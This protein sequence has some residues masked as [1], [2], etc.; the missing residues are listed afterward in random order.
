MVELSSRCLAFAE[1]VVTIICPMLLTLS[2]KKDQ[3]P[4]LPVHILA[5][6]GATV[7]TGICPLL[8][9]CISKTERCRTVGARWPSVTRGF[10]ATISSTCLLVLACWIALRLVSKNFVMFAG[11]VSG[12]GLLL[13][14]FSYWTCSTATEQALLPEMNGDARVAKEKEAKELRSM[15]DKSHELLSGVTGILFLGLGGLALEGLLSTR[16][17]AGDALKVHMTIGHLIC[18]FGVTLMFFPMIPPRA[19]AMKICMVYVSDVTVAVGTAAQLGTIM[20]KLMGRKGFGFLAF[21][22]IILLQLIYTVKIK[23][24]RAAAHE[25]GGKHPTVSPPEPMGGNQGENE[26]SHPTASPPRPNDGDKKVENGRK[27]PTTSP[28][29]PVDGGKQGEN[30]RKNPAASPPGPIDQGSDGDSQGEEFKLAPMG[31]TK[32]TLT[33]FL[34]VS[35]KAISDGS[36][37]EWTVW[38]L[39][40]AAAGIASGVSWRLL[41]HNKSKVGGKPAVEEAANVA[42]FCTHLCVAVATVL[43]AV[44]AFKAGS[45]KECA[46]VSQATFV[47]LNSTHDMQRVKDIC[48]CIS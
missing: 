24:W 33:G 46:H 15:V 11:Y 9:C 35:V 37:S 39:L 45:A 26:G 21:P 30:G 23:P 44:M 34:A 16:N 32:V 2:L 17:G 6:A 22:F 31:L 12:V 18:A 41:T 14:A 36:P 13:R 28:R 25:N 7:V 38:F 5:V 19:A 3:E 48:R 8:A 29:G 47:Q 43:F 20:F 40:F 42:S 4:V 1:G 10:A 27:H